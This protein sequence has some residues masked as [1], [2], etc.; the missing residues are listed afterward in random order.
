MQRRW[1][2][3]LRD[4]VF[5]LGFLRE[6]GVTLAGPNSESGPPV[7]V[8]ASEGLTDSRVPR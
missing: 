8:L 3:P 6:T 4:V 2:E 5:G 7:P 1:S